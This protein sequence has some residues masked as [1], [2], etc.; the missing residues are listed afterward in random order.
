MAWADLTAEQQ[1]AVVDY[2]RNLRA[3][4]GELGRVRTRCGAMD[5]GYGNIQGLLSQLDG[6]E[7]IPDG[8]DLA[9]ALPLNKDEAVTLT[10]HLQTM[11]STFTAGDLPL[12]AK[13]AGPLN[14]VG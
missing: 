6:A 10:S 3:L 12:W 1:A 11:L 14:L 9:G 2:V 7:I 8:S 4:A 5:T 13:A